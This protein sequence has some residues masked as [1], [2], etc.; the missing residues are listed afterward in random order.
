MELKQPLTKLYYSIGEIADLFDVNTSLIR[1]WEKEFQNLHPKKNKSGVR[2]YTTKDIAE[3]H[4][5]YELVKEQG[6]TIDGARKH[7]SAKHKNEE[8]LLH[9]ILEVS[10]TLD[11]QKH[12]PELLDR[13]QSIKE[14]L[15][16]IR[17][18]L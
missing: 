18:S 7:L 17:N 5:I 10:H 13:L 16:G 8:S 12:V 3:F 14:R 1:Y 2:K 11:N 15:L 6:F 9:S 4:K